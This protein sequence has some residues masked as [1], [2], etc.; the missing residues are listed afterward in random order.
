MWWRDDVVEAVC[1]IG[2]EDRPGL[3]YFIIASLHSSKR[4]LFVVAGWDAAKALA[5]PTY[6]DAMCRGVF[7]QVGIEVLGMGGIGP[8]GFD[9]GEGTG[10]GAPATRAVAC[11]K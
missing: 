5:A 1:L 4:M 11:S 7:T 8:V 3:F 9:L 10:R 6:G 2:N